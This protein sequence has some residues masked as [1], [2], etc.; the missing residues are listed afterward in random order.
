VERIRHALR[1]LGPKVQAERMVREYVNALYVPA[2]A[3]SR[4]LTDTDGFGPARE[5]AAWKKLVMQA[6]PQV[7]IEHVESESA[8]GQRLGAALAVRVSVALGQLSRDDV[9]VEVVYG[10][11][12][13]DDEIVR[14]A[15]AT[16]TAEA[17]PAADGA[18]RYSGEVSLVRPGPFGY[19]VRVLPSHRLL[20]S[21]AELGLVTYPQA[22]AGM[23]NGDLR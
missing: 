18:V 6:W 16:L 5:L 3:S 17:A 1:S 8:A 19:T 21:R 7:Q 22:P 10:R 23:T 4:A 9:T 12:D 15:Y 11:P 13:E 20:D 14:P 2:A